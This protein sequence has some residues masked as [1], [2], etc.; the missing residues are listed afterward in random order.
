MRIVSKGGVILHCKS[1]DVVEEVKKVAKEKLGDAYKV[2]IPQK[3]KP[4][5]QIVGF[6]SDINE[7]ELIDFL[8]KQ[9][10]VFNETKLKVLKLYKRDKF[11]NNGAIIEVDGE[12]CEQILA[13]NKVF[14][15]WDRCFMFEYLNVG[16]CF[17]C[18]G[19]NHKAEKCT[20]K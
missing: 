17:K 18:S 8:K 5:I 12:N 9:N 4:K 20:S 2:N 16:M 19:F 13:T 3:I 14:V 11:Q 6:S 10:D 1:S 7:D 15:D